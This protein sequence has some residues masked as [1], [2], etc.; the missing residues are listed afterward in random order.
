MNMLLVMLIT[1]ATLG[2]PPEAPSV[3]ARLLDGSQVRGVLVAWN[4]E[5]IVLEGDSGEHS[6]KVGHLAQLV[7]GPE[8]PAIA[9]MRV[10]LVDGSVL[11]VRE[12]R[13]SGRTVQLVMTDGSEVAVAARLVQAV[14]FATIPAELRQAWD[15]SLAMDAASDWLVLPAEG[16]LDHVE[17]V[18][19]DVGPERLDFTL[20]GETISVARRKVLG[21]IYRHPDRALAPVLCRLR[22]RDGSR[23]E[24]AAVELRDR[25]ERASATL[26]LTTAAGGRFSLP[27]SRV[28]GADFSSGRVVYLSELPREQ[29]T[30]TPRIGLVG[31]R[32][33][34]DVVEPAIDGT[35]GG[36]P[37]RLGGTSH[38]RGI[39][40]VSRTEVVYRLPDDAQQFRAVVGID[41]TSRPAG[42]ARLRI[43]VDGEV[44]F[45]EA[46]TGVQPPG[47]VTLDVAGARRLT[48]VADF[49]DPLRDVGYVDLCEARITK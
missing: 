20:E 44:R 2:A 40:L 41:D 45:D 25:S 31:G 29:V 11:A 34:T 10:G 30:Y 6:I 17:G 22:D 15:E 12:Y 5:A 32:L 24:V 18:T 3:V 47:E 26:G 46:L 13:A 14:Q 35:P 19:G 42:T 9:G 8:T 48:I 21:V 23:Y 7:A 38:A 39:S 28:A 4:D 49:G 16:A 43:E 36:E 27:L 37:L 1:T 33:P